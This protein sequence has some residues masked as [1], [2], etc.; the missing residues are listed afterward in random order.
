MLGNRY[1]A[2][3]YS[4][5]VQLNDMLS[6]TLI[7]LGAS[8]VGFAVI[9]MLLGAFERYFVGMGYAWINDLPPLLMPWL[10]FPILGVIIRT[11]QHI[12]VEIAP[13]MLNG[14]AYNVLQIA[15]YTVCFVAALVFCIGSAG[16]V[17]FF[18][19][20]GEVTELEFELPKWWI[21]LALTVGF[22]LLA[23]FSLEKII[24]E[25][26][27]LAKSTSKKEK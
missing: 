16:A 11:D 8:I 7:A 1:M 17:A 12:K 18:R 19:H 20:L 6:K 21:Y 10:V 27:K 24:S 3:V 26:I 22:G 13:S 5:Y 25:C 23:N 4:L 15:V 2:R 9:S 14:R